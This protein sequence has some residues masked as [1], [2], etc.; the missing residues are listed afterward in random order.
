[1]SAPAFRRWAA[2]VVAAGCL[3][4]P[5]VSALAAA[6]T[7]SASQIARLALLR[8]ADLGR[9]WSV[10]AAA[11][12]RAPGLT[13][14]GF[15][16]R[17]P[18]VHLRAAVASPTFQ[19]SAQGPFLSQAA[20]LYGSG[21]QQRVAWRRIVT[22]RL[23]RCAAA[24]LATGSGGGASFTVT[25]RRVSSLRRPKG[26]VARYRVG[27]NATGAGQTMPVYLDELVLGRAALITVLDVSSFDAPPSDALERHLADLADAGL[28]RV[29]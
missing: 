6:Q 13:C 12:A 8:K 25:S 24:A 17:L 20:Y 10:A 11:P 18:G 16:P 1:M 7:H 22:P 15:S 2:V 26:A 29:R 14:R 3:L 27:G 19:Q 23:L 5:A 28:R 4:G 9:G 21:I